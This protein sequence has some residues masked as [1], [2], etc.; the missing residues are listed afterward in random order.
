MS[1]L[2]CI[3][4]T[5]DKYL[6]FE[7]HHLVQLLDKYA[8]N[9]LSAAFSVSYSRFLVLL[10]VYAHKS[11]TQHQ[12]ANYVGIGDAVVSRMLG[13]LQEQGLLKV[14]QDARHAKKN[15]VVLTPKGSR[16]VEKASKQLES[17]FLELV[18]T[19]G[20]DSTRFGS[21]IASMNIVLQSKKL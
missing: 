8:D 17:D 18:S 12:I 5:M 14:V 6:S 10:A 9:Y 13:P 2:K 3:L 20:V 16:L 15:N 1:T 7:L 4:L 21:D 19:S 11:A